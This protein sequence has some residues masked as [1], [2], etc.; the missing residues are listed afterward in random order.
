LLSS[1]SL[2]KLSG[3]GRT[4]IVKFILLSSP[5]STKVGDLGQTQIIKFI[6]LSF[7]LLLKQAA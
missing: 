3:M 2:T 1:T 6:L 4:Q 7:P 5:P